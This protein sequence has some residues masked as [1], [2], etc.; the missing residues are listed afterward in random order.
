MGLSSAA[1][2]RRSHQGHLRKSQLLATTGTVPGVGLN[3][4]T[5]RFPAA[6][7]EPNPAQRTDQ[8]TSKIFLKFFCPH[9]SSPHLSFC[10]IPTDIRFPISDL[11]GC[12]AGTASRKK[13]EIPGRPF[14]RMAP[15][16]AR[17]SGLRGSVT[18]ARS[19]LRRKPRE[20]FGAG[21]RSPGGWVLLVESSMPW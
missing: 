19:M 10:R 7:P 4:R 1:R 2:P 21:N 9:F 3:Y 12:V 6:H 14:G 20:A 17:L 18:S 16:L 5:S 11:R 8:T 15:V 13:G